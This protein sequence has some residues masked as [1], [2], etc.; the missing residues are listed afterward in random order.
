[1]TVLRTRNYVLAVNKRERS[2][3][4]TTAINGL[5]PAVDLSKSPDL[6]LN[7]FYNQ[8]QNLVFLLRLKQ[9]IT[10]LFIIL[11]KFKHFVQTISRMLTF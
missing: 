5:Q 2:E 10:Q 6:G 7:V 4:A 11:N 8:L 3:C 9:K 1:M